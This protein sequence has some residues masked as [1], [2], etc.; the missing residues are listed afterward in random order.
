[1]ADFGLAGDYGLP[2]TSQLYIGGMTV[3]DALSKKTVSPQI[4]PDQRFWASPPR[5]MTYRFS[6]GLIINL[7]KPKRINYLSLDLPQFPHHF[8]FYWWDA[9]TWREF[10]G[11]STGSIRIYIDGSAPAVVGPA[12]AYQAHQHPS[13]YGAGHWLHYDIDV[14]PITTS[15]IRIMGNRDFGSRKGGPVDTQGK[16][17]KYSLGV[18]NLD[19][20]WRVRTKADVPRTSRD[21]DILTQNESFTTTLDLLGSPVELKLRE[22]RA[23]DVLRG[24]VWKS[25]PMPVPYA[26]VNFYVDA[27]DPYGQPQVIDRFKLTPLVAGASLNLYY[28]DEVPGDDFTA[29]DDPIVFPSLR[30]AGEVD[31]AV[32]PS[33]ILF[34]NKISY[35]DLDNATVQWDATAPFWLGLQ[36]QPQ[37]DS[38]DT[39]PHVIFDT[40]PLQLSWNGTAFQLNHGAGSLSMQPFAFA[41]N[42]RLNVL[43][44]FDGQTLAFFVPEVGAVATVP[45]RMEGMETQK[46]RFGAELGDTGAP[47]IYTGAF[48]LGALLIKQEG[49]TF[50]ADQLG[51]VI[52]PGPMAQFITDADTYLDKPEYQRDEDGSTNNAV[53]RFLP[54]FCLGS[55]PTSAN[56]F[57]FVGGPGDIY[58]EVVWTPVTRDYKLRAGMLQFNPARAKFFKFEFTNLTPEPYQTYTPL[59][60]KV[61]T[62][63][64]GATRPP[65]NPQLTSQVQRSA[66]S[67]GLTANQDATIQTVRYADTPAITKPVTNDVLPTE[68]LTARDL[69]IQNKLDGIGGL[70]RF[71]SWQSGCAAPPVYTATSRHYYE[72]IEVGHSKKIAYFVGL[73]DIRMFRV[74]YT[75]DDDTEQYLEFFDDR[76]NIDPTYI[77][78]QVV[79]G[80]TN[81]VPNPS[82]ENGTTGHTLY[83][84]G[85]ATAGAIATIA[86]P[87]PDVGGATALKVSAS[88]L[89]ATTSDRVGFQATY[90]VPANGSIGYSIYA[91]KVTGNATVRL[92]VEYYAAGSVFISSATQ[93]FTPGTAY[94]RLSALLLPPLLTVTVKVYW[95]LEA[96]AA[97]AVDYRFD[98]YQIEP[99]RITDYYDGSLAG[100]K[101]NGTVNNSTSTR[102]AID[103]KPWLWDGDRLMTS[104]TEPLTT[105]SNRFSS[106]RRVRGIQFAT[107]QSQ[108]VQLLP[109]PDFNDPNVNTYWVPEGDAV[110]MEYSEDIN[111][112]LGK[113]VKLFRSSAVNTWGEL[114]AQFATWGAVLASQDGAFL[115]QYGTLEGDNTTVGF[116]GMRLRNPVQVSE[117]GRVVAAA[118]VYADHALSAPLKLQIL[119]ADGQILAEASQTVTAGRVIE[120]SVGYTVGSTPTIATTWFDIMQRDPSATAPTYGDLKAGRW[121]DL[122]STTVSQQRNLS[123]RLIQEGAGD[124][125]WYV[126]SIALFDDPIV[127]EFSNDD[128]ATWWRAIDIRNNPRGVLIFPNSLSPTP[129]DP[130]GLRW[131]VTGYRPGLH[132]SSLDIR[133]WYAE[134]VF[135]IP[136]RE[137]GVSGGPNIQPTDHYTKIEEDPFFKQWSQPVPQD[138]FF[139][140]RQL[141]LL[142]HQ[143]VAVEAVVKPDVFLNSMSLLVKVEVE[144]PPEPF[145]DLY[146]NNYTDLYGQV[147]P[148][149]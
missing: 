58:S 52:V 61:K 146:E 105:M 74:D 135:G 55:D 108:P 132:V 37:F 128:G 85:T 82:F 68:A 129:A 93:T 40:G 69:G 34:Q 24:Q 19:F 116:G 121:A 126:D 23:A 103:I 112:T 27:R 101:W 65:A 106:R 136:H 119:S 53:L 123:A 11:P 143:T 90:T 138:W 18:R 25:E 59:T 31:P 92:T 2:A 39:T 1:M 46:I 87:A 78:G 8:Y 9:G 148:D 10:T 81:Y 142:D 84:N 57:G 30:I 114:R 117:A 71:D 141:L 36:I 4:A 7:A 130:T 35:L 47:V 26:V 41:Q 115:P 63:S 79:I 33:G 140:Y 88:T 111:A 50:E 133:P 66:T 28:S 99:L 12:V 134:T 14:N 149:A 64:Q 127:W 124:E 32:Q 38:S 122:T 144:P 96:G 15:K 5:L 62:F 145:F 77:T 6:D 113:A 120:W 3:D 118:R 20:G 125:T 91:K 102:T 48:R 94:E 137:A 147:N 104:G 80:T 72:E 17:A 73:S 51:V 60:R 16:P 131:R 97:A 95:W 75:A 44:S 43:I 89:G 86:D 56:Q 139:T 110:S 29:S 42:A 70:Y 83:T 67:T 109:D 13:H 76:K 107:Q 54:R 49:L 100:G 98:A 45:T 21:P 22:N